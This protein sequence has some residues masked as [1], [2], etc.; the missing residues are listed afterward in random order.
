MNRPS[1]AYNGSDIPLAG[2]EGSRLTGPLASSS[3]DDSIAPRE[4]NPCV[5]LTGPQNGHLTSFSTS[6]PTALQGRPSAAPE[7]PVAAPQASRP[8][9]LTDGRWNVSSD[10]RQYNRPS[11]RICTPLDA[12]LYPPL[13]RPA[14]T[15]VGNRPY[16]RADSRWSDRSDARWYPR[17]SG[18]PESRTYMEMDGRYYHRSEDRRY[19]RRY[20]RVDSRDYLDREGRLLGRERTGRAYFPYDGRFY[21]SVDGPS[22]QVAVPSQEGYRQTGFAGQFLG[23]EGMT[24]QLPPVDSLIGQGGFSMQ[25]NGGQHPYDPLAIPDPANSHYSHAGPS[26]VGDGWSF[27]SAPQ[28]PVYH[29]TPHQD[30]GMLRSRS[31]MPSDTTH[32][33]PRLLLDA[34]FGGTNSTMSDSVDT[35]PM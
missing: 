28:Q 11:D 3:V 7:N 17:E 6:A 19:D 14:Y 5:C 10:N 33:R 16:G 15:P 21:S 34:D 26:M 30:A 32:S 2:S 27:G 24:G 23:P 35:P 25:D 22:H 13:G 9:N 18:R 20:T 8:N 29:Y 4:D 31:V 12:A 1:I